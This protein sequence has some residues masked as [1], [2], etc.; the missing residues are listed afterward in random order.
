MVWWN[1]LVIGLIG[2]FAISFYFSSNTIIYYLMR[3]EVDATELDDVY[4]EETDDDVEDPA[5]V[6]PAGPATI[7]ETATVRVYEAQERPHPIARR[8]RRPP[9]DRPLREDRPKI[10]NQSAA[11]VAQL[12]RASV[13]GTKG[14]RFEPYRVHFPPE[15]LPIPPACIPAEPEPTQS[16]PGPDPRRT[17]CVAQRSAIRMIHRAGSLHEFLRTGL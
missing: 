7:R 6:A 13:F 3:R 8:T 12:D 15:L 16:R 11:L 5:T 2:A 10:A 1:Y 14:C 9:I 4:V 17:R